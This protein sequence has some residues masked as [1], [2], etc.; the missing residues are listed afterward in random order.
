MAPGPQDGHEGIAGLGV[1]FDDVDLL[2]TLE[3]CAVERRAQ[4]G[5]GGGRTQD[6]R[7]VDESVGGE[8]D[9]P[10]AHD[11]A[12]AEVAV[13]PRG[14]STRPALG[15]L[16]PG[17]DVRHEPRD[18]AC[19]ARQ[20]A[21]ERVGVLGAR[22]GGDRILLLERQDVGPAARDAV[23]RDA[24]V[25]QP[26]D[27]SDQAAGIVAAEVALLDE[28]V[29]PAGL[30]QRPSGPRQRLGVTQP[31]ASFLEVG[32]EH[33]GD[34]AELLAPD[35]GGRAQVLDQPGAAPL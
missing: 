11:D 12:S 5:R 28:R 18:R 13:A 19:R 16:E 35:L 20:I 27:R 23:Q 14:T 31:A 7:G 30:A 21:H 3:R 2:R 17:E 33:L 1:P 24:N 32:L 10:V 22:L 6:E 9:P 29:P 8:R 26:P 34:E 15:R 25:E 4:L